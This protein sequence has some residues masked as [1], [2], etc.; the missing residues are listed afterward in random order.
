[1]RVWLFA[2]CLL[3]A[4][5]GSG[6]AESKKVR[7]R[8]GAI[9]TPPRAAVLAPQSLVPEPA[10][11]GLFLVQL[12]GNL[13]PA[14]RAQLNAAGADPLRYVP[15]DA[16]VVRLRSTELARLRALPFVR[17]IGPFR[18]E[19]KLGPG[20]WEAARRANADA[21]SV[22][23]RALLAPRTSA[24]E[25]TQ[26]LR[27]VPGLA[28]RST[29]RFGTVV[30][31]RIDAPQLSALSESDAVLWIEP[32]PRPRLYDEVSSKIVGGGE[33][34]LSSG[35]GGL[36]G[37]GGD[38]DELGLV[39]VRAVQNAGS[40]DAHPT[41][42]QQLGFD[43]R[44]V[45]VA[46]ADSG[47]HNGDA[48]S[49]HRDLAGRASEF[50]FY[51]NLTDAAD[52][53]GHGTHVAG[54][55]GGDGA[56]GETDG[57]NTLYGL[58]VAP[59]ARIV[60]QRI[61][62]G[63]GGYEAPPT[64][65][66]LTRDAVRAGAE[67]GSNSWGDDTQ[68]RYDLSAAEF[69]ALVRDADAEE[70][71]DQ[72]YILEFSAG[73]AG[74]GAQTIG[75][76]AV[77]KNVIA[78]GA[79]QN[80]RT[81]FVI[82]GEGQEAMA[83]FSSRGP[84]EDGRIKPD[85]VAP[86]TWIASLQ[87]ASAPDSNAWLPI[88]PNYQYQGGTSQS[89][90]HVSGAAAVFVQFYR[91]TRTNAT[92]SPALV[93]AALINSASD[94]LD[95]EGGTEPIPNFDEGW[96]RVTLTN[97]IG[98]VRRFEFHDQSTALTNG[99]AFERRVLVGHPD[100]PLKVTLVYTDVPGFPAAIP[101]L[102]NDLDLEVV[103]PDGT[104]F[105]GNQFDHGASIPNPLAADTI[106][107]VE[108]V[109]VPQP[110]PGEYTVRVR[111]RSVSE[112]I[113]GRTNA[114]P[115]QDFALVISADLPLPG[116]GVLIFDRHAYR[117]PAEIQ[118][119]LIDFDLARQASVPLRVH[120]DSEPLGELVTLIA[121]GSAGVFTN[122]L[123]TA[124]GPASADGR[125]QVLHDD[126]IVARYDDQT[127]P[128]QRQALARADLEPPAITAVSTRSQFGRAVVAWETDEPARAVVHYGTNR[129]ALD[130]VVARGDL[131]ETHELALPGLT[132]GQTNFFLVVS[133]DEAGNTATNDNGG[134]RFAVVA[135]PAPPILLVDAY[136]DLLFNDVATLSTYTDALDAT[137]IAYELWEVAAQGRAPNLDELRPF[138]VV[139]WRVAE[140]APTLSTADVKNIRDYVNSGG[141]LFIASMEV[142][143]RLDESGFENFRRNILNVDTYDVDPGAE[144]IYGSD[145]L[146]LTSGVDTGLDFS[147]YDELGLGIFSFN[148]ADT[149]HP[150]TNAVPILFDNQTGM[151]VG[152]RYPAAGSD[153]PGRVVF[154]AFPLDTVS[155]TGDA[156]NTRPA[157]LRNVVS[158]LAPGIHGLGSLEMD[159][160]EYT[161]PAR[162]AIEVAD[163]DLAG[164]GRLEVRFFSD[165]L[166]QGRAVALEEST[167]P[168]LFRGVVALVTTNTPAS[169]GQVRVED[170][171]LIRIEYRD[172]SQ[173]RTI[174]VLAVV[175]LSGPQIDRVRAV[176]DYS[177]A[178][179]EWQTS[180]W[181]DALVQFHESAFPFPL[182]RTAYVADLSD[183][184]AVTLT[185]LEPD[186]DYFFQVVSR[187][188]A[189]NTTVDD[190]QG[191]LYRF[192]TLKPLTPPFLDTLEHN[193]TNWTVVNDTLD[194]ETLSILQSSVWQLGAPENELASQ[195]FSGTNCW[196]T[197]LRGEPNDFANSSLITPAIHLA[198][199][200][201]AT[202]QF[203]HRYDFL[204]RNEESDILE[205]GGVFVTTNNGALWTQLSQYEDALDAWEPETLDLTPYLGHV[206]R[207]GWAY[208]LFSIDAV[209]HPGWLVD[210]ISITVSNLILG[211]LRVTNNVA[212]AAF[213][214]R[215][216]IQRAGQGL[217]GQFTNAPPG[218]YAIEFGAV[219]YYTTPPARN[220]S[221]APGGSLEFQGVYTID[222]TN[223]NAIADAWEQAFLG[224]VTAGR[225][226]L[227]DSDADGMA[228][229]AEFLAGTNPTNALSA[230]VL[231]P[232]RRV[233]SER[234]QLSWPSAPGRA[235]RVHGSGDAQTWQP[236]SGWIRTTRTNAVYTLPAF[237]NG[238]PYLFRIEARP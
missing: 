158:F 48:G 133:T 184:H 55:V 118:I 84:C 233:T 152:L 162:V 226:G 53:H 99:Q 207:V 23:V 68:G 70:P 26:L 164:S 213:T 124:V 173:Q 61:F 166:P 57:D 224:G 167:R 231:A 20:L 161:A 157:L 223:Q 83:D 35:E 27:R 106:N 65:E 190:N 174:E 80:N 115:A 208:A 30:S 60:A 154:F 193:T 222:D 45:T 214:I 202:L 136:D 146:S 103:G 86:G 170:G 230:L 104:R 32:A 19:Y 112:D 40:A 215:G 108:A 102:V 198:G 29:T 82:Y 126:E 210:D 153:A 182:N 71:G 38:D 204:P 7:L 17:W 142:L 121:S 97:M 201:W 168:G 72:P 194:E 91:E 62:D 87:S 93:K 15:D 180:E 189:G 66:T 81:A 134:L 12:E 92:P 36:G 110:P 141:G 203:M 96:G 24:S 22:E 101:A 188:V 138:Q 90:P 117:A 46:V 143:S 130:R 107:N 47:L 2:W 109:H 232:P 212:Q 111:A 228:D 191:A 187:D 3:L 165:R 98:G 44:G 33:V 128:G 219:P 52:E 137:G 63:D 11:S 169:S 209:A 217:A 56:L 192:R 151:P 225:T 185:G 14:W 88:S 211:T 31:G 123:A 178:V 76:P 122:A 77:A 236:V 163:S 229:V 43:G 75:S 54:I 131:R 150:T 114:A 4:L 21:R 205:L 67:I 227:E 155:M 78:S 95:E 216:P 42:T 100:Q 175:D 79:S 200:N 221:L 120:S 199:G 140:L 16:F 37:G 73:N 177:D 237:T 113:H 186:R 179:I 25:T 132:A 181:T 160:G 64:F 148:L 69:D 127:P 218:E 49:M 144:G 58:G 85:V 10:V 13:R 1:V 149:F 159:R 156:P 145:N 172:A 147:A 74:P 220:L 5:A 195:A 176:P 9:E 41:V 18:P 125:L 28:R 94:M 129:L 234:M 89:G 34:D 119:R 183:T 197:N 171:D 116:E 206:I 59:K 135:Q 51:G 196:G 6:A 50:F 139:I 39:A 105:G 8:S 235:Y 238:A